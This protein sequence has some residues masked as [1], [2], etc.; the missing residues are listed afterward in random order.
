MGT[1]GRSPPSRA[2]RGT[3]SS[4]GEGGKFPLGGHAQGRDVGSE[5]RGTKVLKEVGG[6]AQPGPGGLRASSEGG[7]QKWRP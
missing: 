5:P 6:A 1:L 2:R 7:G 4:L 3:H